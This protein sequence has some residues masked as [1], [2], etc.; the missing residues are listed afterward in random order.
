[1][2]V[3]KTLVFAFLF[4]IFSAYSQ[5]VI[6]TKNQGNIN[7]KVIEIGTAEIKYK[8]YDNLD[9]PVIVIRKNEVRKIQYANGQEN[10]IVPDKYSI[11]QEEQIL[12]K[13]NAIK[14]DFFSP[15][16]GYVGIGYER[17]LKVG[18]NLETKV[19]LVGPGVHL[20][21]E[22]VSGGFV[23][24]GT[25]F[26]LGQDFVMDGMRYA[27]PLKGTFLSFELAYSHF[28]DKNVESYTYNYTNYTYS[29]DYTDITTNS[30][31]INIIVGKQWILGNMFT[32][33]VYGG[34]GYG[35]AFRSSSNPTINANDVWTVYNPFHFSH[36]YCGDTFPLTFTSGLSL[37]YIF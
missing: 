28:T 33:D 8:S 36:F 30:L 10:I 13:Q 23:K 1:M 18:M 37:G 21:R 31:A 22:D 20:L 15:L 3:L 9:G 27:H 32:L 26:L 5:D 6:Y 19:G 17:V 2:K 35:K 14:F 4:S 12:N 16:K 29:Y 11:N 25:K 24:V 7:A 34:T